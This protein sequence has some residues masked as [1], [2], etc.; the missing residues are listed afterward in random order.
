M[1]YTASER[2]LPKCALHSFLLENAL[3]YIDTNKL[4]IMFQILINF[5]HNFRWTKVLKLASKAELQNL[6][7]ELESSQNKADLKRNSSFTSST[8]T[9]NSIQSAD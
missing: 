9:T 7:E 4:F 6:D 2:N 8:S 3:T 5:Y 1:N